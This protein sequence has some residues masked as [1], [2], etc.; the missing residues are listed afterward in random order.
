MSLHLG[1]QKKERQ[2]QTHVIRKFLQATQFTKL[3]MK[4][5]NFLRRTIGIKFE[6]IIM[7]K[8]LFIYLILIFTIYSCDKGES[9]EA[10]VINSSSQKLK[11]N[12]VSSDIS[13]LNKSLEIESN[14]QGLYVEFQSG[15][16]SVFLTFVDNDSIYIQN[17]S[18]KVLKV[19]K[20]DTSGK[21]IYNVDKYW[22]KRE[23][24]KNFFEYTY[25]ITDEDIK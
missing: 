15:T 4:F 21:N 7:K 25:E 1:L 14:Q 16:S 20:A 19:Y 12:F 9:M 24:S 8:T 11:V 17:S 6:L 22:Q 2:T 13:E 3:K 18:N 23:P 10:F 5:E